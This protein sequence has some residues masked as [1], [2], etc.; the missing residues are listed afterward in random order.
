MEMNLGLSERVAKLR[1]RVSEIIRNDI[2]PL[3]AEYHAEVSKGGPL[4]IDRSSGGNHDR[5]E[6]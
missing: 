6:R 2:M 4:D 5:A 1:D 3:E